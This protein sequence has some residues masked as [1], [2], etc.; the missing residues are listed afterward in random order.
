MA[1][2]KGFPFPVFK[3]PLGFLYSQIG[4]KNLKSDLIQLI[5]TNPGD[6]V[7][8]PQYGTALR[9]YIFEQNTDATKSAIAAEISNSIST[10]EPR[11]TVTAITV[12]DL[13]EKT[14]AGYNSTN[15]N[16]V[17][18]RINYINPEKINIIEELVLAVPFEGG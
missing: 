6:R 9:K 16:G 15:K 18:I 14:E 13:V 1:D 4:A 12:T 10:W 2:L 8:L 3:N 17:L 11:I 7:M 5:L